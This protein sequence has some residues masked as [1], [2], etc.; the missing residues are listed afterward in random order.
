MKTWFCRDCRK[1]RNK[2]IEVIDNIR[3]ARNLFSV[4]SRP[5]PVSDMTNDIVDI[6]ITNPPALLK[7]AG[8]Y[9]NFCGLRPGSKRTDD[10]FR[11]V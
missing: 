11:A 8:Q 2:I 7:S 3:C 6:I 5:N 1:F 9:A 4:G 10:P